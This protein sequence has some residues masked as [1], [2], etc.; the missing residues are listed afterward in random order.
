VRIALHNQGGA[1]P[2]KIRAIAEWFAR[3]PRLVLQKEGEFY[4]NDK[5]SLWGIGYV[6][7][8]TILPFMSYTRVTAPA[9]IGGELLNTVRPYNLVFREKLHRIP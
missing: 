2:I 3:L 6:P 1:S 8:N 7:N 5:V 9:S 4:Y